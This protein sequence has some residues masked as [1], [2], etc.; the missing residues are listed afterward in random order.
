MFAD[1]D[2]RIVGIERRTPGQHFV[3]H[4]AEA[5]EVGAPVTDLT[6][7]LL[8]AHVMRAAH[9]H[10]HA[11]RLCLEDAE[12]G[13]HRRAVGAKQDVRRLDVAV[14]DALRVRVLERTGELLGDAQ[15][16]H[17]RHRLLQGVAQGA[18]RNELG[19]DIRITAG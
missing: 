13:E 6:L 2:E 12:V 11:G 5:V 15:G 1:H 9:L 8:G 3:E 4:H 10:R 17:R 16:V 7:D 14:H 18:A 19:R